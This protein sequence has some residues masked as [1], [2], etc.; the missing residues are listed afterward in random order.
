MGKRKVGVV[1]IGNA[2]TKSTS[3]P[4]KLVYAVTW[5]IKED[6]KL[7]TRCKAQEIPNES[8]YFKGIVT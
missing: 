3:H 5:K 4:L 2:S 7:G 6:L 8:P 1:D